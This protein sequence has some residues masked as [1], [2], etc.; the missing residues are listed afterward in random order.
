MNN[1]KLDGEKVSDSVNLLVSM[2]VRYPELGTLR[3]D[4][5]NATLNLTLF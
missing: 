5:S 3:F 4:S 1:F 2:L